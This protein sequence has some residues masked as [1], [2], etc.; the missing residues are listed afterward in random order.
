MLC[1][2]A[3][4]CQRIW[5]AEATFGKFADFTVMTKWKG[6]FVKLQVQEPVFFKTV[7]F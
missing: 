3:L 2:F 1:G 6:L 5:D 7:E 4:S